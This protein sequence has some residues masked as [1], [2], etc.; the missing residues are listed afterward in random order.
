MKPSLGEGRF[1]RGS[2]GRFFPSTGFTCLASRARL[3][4]MPIQSLAT[5][6]D[7]DA[8]EWDALLPPAQ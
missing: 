6:A 7:I 8:A 5:L 3:A 4:R 1:H 2:A